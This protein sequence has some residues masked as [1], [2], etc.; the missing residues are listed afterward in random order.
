M[1]IILGLLLVT[2]FSACNN[3]PYF[4]PRATQNPF[5]PSALVPGSESDINA[6]A[7]A[8]G[9]NSGWS[10]SGTCVRRP[11]GFCM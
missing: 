2:L 10:N 4:A 6:P 1:K 9:L 7:R 5:K 11:D 8:G 3:L